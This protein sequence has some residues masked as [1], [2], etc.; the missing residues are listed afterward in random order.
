MMEKNQ[1]DYFVI[2]AKENGVHVIGLT[3]DGYALSPYG[4]AG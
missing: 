4:K 1:G 3:G 2:K